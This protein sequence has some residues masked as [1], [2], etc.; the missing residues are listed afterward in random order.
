VETWAPTGTEAGLFENWNCEISETGLDDGDALVLYS[1]A[2][3]KRN[4]ATVRHLA[5]TG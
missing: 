1:D 3:S 5:K 2:S 4:A